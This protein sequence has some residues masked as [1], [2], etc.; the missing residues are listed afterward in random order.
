LQLDYPGLDG[1]PD[2]NISLGDW[3]TIARRDNGVS[4]LDN[5]DPFD[6][7]LLFLDPAPALDLHVPQTPCKILPW[8]LQEHTWVKQQ[9]LV[10]PDCVLNLEYEPFIK[11]VG[12]MLHAWVRTG[13]NGF[14]HQQLYDSGMPTCLQSAFTTLGAYMASTPAMRATILQIADDHA[15]ALVCQSLPTVSGQSLIV[16]HLARIHALFVYTYMRLF[17]GSVRLRASAE[18]QI[19]TL[20]LWVVQMWEASRHFRPE[21]EVSPHD[22]FE[23]ANIVTDFSKRYESSQKLWKLW[24]MFESVRRTHVL[25]DAFLN[26]YDTMTKGCALCNG[27]VSFTAAAGFWEAPSASQWVELF[28]GRTQA[29]LVPSLEPE[30]WLLRHPGEPVDDFVRTCWACIVG[31]EKLQGWIENNTEITPV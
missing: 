10:K 13:S 11:S 25:T 14:I 3:S 24:A 9:P 5:T 26:F 28:R 19:P 12:A 17:D 20:R 7:A 2:A 16:A 29:I 15:T 6:P 22:P 27:A 31:T 18:K 23:L 8:F 1:L 30:A 4:L 21:P